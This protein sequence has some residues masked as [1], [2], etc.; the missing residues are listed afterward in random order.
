MQDGQ[1]N[2][3]GTFHQGDGTPIH[4]LYRGD[5]ETIWPGYEND[6][7][8]VTW[9]SD[10]SEQDPADINYHI[11]DRV[12]VGWFLPQTDG[13]IEYNDTDG[14]D[15]VEAAI[16][17]GD[18]LDSEITAGMGGGSG[19]DGYHDICDT[20]SARDN[21]ISEMSS[22]L[23][24]RGASGVTHNWEFPDAGTESEDYLRLIRDISNQTSY[25]Q[26]LVI[27]P[28]NE[29]HIGNLHDAAVTLGYEDL[30]EFIS[31]YVDTSTIMAYP[32][33]GTFSTYTYHESPLFSPWDDEYPDASPDDEAVYPPSVN[34]ICW[35]AEY[36]YGIDPGQLILGT[37]MD[38]PIYVD[39]TD[40]GDPTGFLQEHDNDNGRFTNWDD[41]FSSIVDD[42]D[43]ER[44]WHDEYQAA[45]YWNSSTSELASFDDMDVI[46]RK[47]EYVV[48]ND[49]AGLMWF[50]WALDDDQDAGYASDD[51]IHSHVAGP[52]DE[53]PDTGYEVGSTDTMYS[54]DFI[55][56]DVPDLA[57]EGHVLVTIITRT[58]PSSV[59]PDSHP[60]WNLLDYQSESDTALAVYARTATDSEPE[61]YTFDWG[62]A[63]AIMEAT[64]IA[65][66]GVAEPTASDVELVYGSDSTSV[67]VPQQSVEDGD[68]SVAAGSVISTGDL[69]FDPPLE[70]DVME[71]DYL[72]VGHETIDSSGDTPSRTFENTSSGGMVGC[73][74]VS[75]PN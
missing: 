52:S 31:L 35:H 16:D 59:A 44:Q 51:V 27:G 38:G 43:W 66:E 11:H 74:I 34:Y 24:T 63:E 65:F 8:L 73:S 19:S 45:T 4:R 7:T 57:E 28:H 17:N 72:R 42:P 54:A 5:G 60:D 37:S 15:K 23:D 33:A 3:I 6:K 12:T 14:W 9:Y 49:F 46:R 71:R 20:Q 53:P 56:V 30:G 47:A 36:N 25:T 26:H 1:G 70:F 22:M 10:W 41:E 21:A 18:T 67:S 50:A 13:S 62:S 32:L 55:P 58:W 75:S 29:S 61:E 68:L 48:D 69:S 39:V 40:D 2:P 64:M